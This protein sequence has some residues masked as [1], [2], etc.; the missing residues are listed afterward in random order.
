[1]PAV[2]VP[3]GFLNT[4]PQHG[5]SN[6]VPALRQ[7]NSRPC[8]SL[9]LAGG[10]SISA[11]LASSTTTFP[12]FDARYLNEICLRGIWRI[13]PRPSITV[14]S[15]RTSVNSAPCAPAF[16]NTPPPAKL[17]EV[18]GRL[19]RWRKAG[20]PFDLPCCGSVFKNPSGTRT[21]GMLIDECGLK[22]FTIG[23]AQV[24][25]LHANYIVNTGTASASDVLKVIEHVRKT[26]AKRTG[27]ELELEV[28]VIGA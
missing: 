7:R 8:T 23:G 9:S 25:P 18:Q 22:G 24:S 15:V 3:L 2:R 5:R 21:A 28:K 11:S 20:T 12:R 26:V 13:L 17:K 14:H 27:V 1:M 16:M 19:F 4:E 10:S 6:G